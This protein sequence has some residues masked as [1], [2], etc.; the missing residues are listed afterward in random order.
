MSSFINTVSSIMNS[1]KWTKIDAITSKTILIGMVSL[2]LMVVIKKIFD[3]CLWYRHYIKIM[4]QVPGPE[5]THWLYGN[6]HL[7]TEKHSDQLKLGSE[8]TARFPRMYKFW[9]GPFN[10]TIVLNHPETIKQVLKYA[11]SKSMGFGGAYRH[12]YPWLG[13]G[14][15]LAD[16]QRWSRAR[17]LLTPA[18]HFKILKPY[19]HIYNK[20]TDL[21]L[22]KF[23]HYAERGESFDLLKEM[24]LCTLDILLQ[25]IFSME[26]D[27]QQRESDYVK[28][29]LK[30][31]EIWS[32]RNR[33]LWLFPD[34][35]FYNT[36]WGKQFKEHCSKVHDIA[37]NII[38]RRQQEIDQLDGMGERPYLD[39]L[40]LLLQA[41]D[42]DGNKLT[43]A[44][45][46]N[47]VD[48]F[49]FEGHDT[50]A[51]SI[52]WLLHLLAQH[53]NYQQRV[54]QELDRI[55]TSKSTEY[56]QWEDLPHFEYLTM[57]LKESLR[58]SSTVPIIQRLVPREIT[59]DGK[60]FPPNTLFTIAINSVHHNPAVWKNPD[61][62]LPD[63]FSKENISNIDNFSYIPFSAGPRNCIGQNFALNEEKVVLSRI[64]KNFTVTLDPS[65]T[66]EKKIGPV[67]KA[68]SGI[69]VFLTK[70]N[71]R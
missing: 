71:I 15:L 49:L 66:V 25:C 28:S 8:L 18:F 61:E 69:H 54:Q 60:D 31:G 17:R 32:K 20:A 10:A 33:K 50:T 51:S 52:S 13:E 4:K 16:G 6:L 45:I 34:V 68:E 56:V 1:L 46:R 30:L 63:R 58:A 62:Y 41:K 43:D 70:R 14:L 5:N 40:D 37:Q 21:L 29:V 53:Q 22:Q 26:T 2:M 23:E 44:E 19:I 39:F 38:K 42:E 35:I 3:F 64:L 55:W 48:T 36:R 65:F 27:C 59:I 57:C 9:V 67:L 24:S 7:L 11:D 47:E 12:V